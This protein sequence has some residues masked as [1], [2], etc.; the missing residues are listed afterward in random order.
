MDSISQLVGMPMDYFILALVALIIAFDAWRSGPNRAI[1]LS[2]AFALTYISL[3]WASG[4]YFLNTIEMSG[5]A[6]LG[7][8][9]VKLIALY[10]ILNRIV[11]SFGFGVGGPATAL[12]AGLGA[13]AL[14]IVFWIATPTFND[15]WTF[16]PVIQSI[17]GEAFRAWWLIGSFALLA[18]ARG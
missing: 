7:I 18:F 15:L 13:T 17:F 10:F 14:S 11:N 12:A 2:L 9:F 4:T 6:A 1:A 5:Y 8:A 3:S 16:G